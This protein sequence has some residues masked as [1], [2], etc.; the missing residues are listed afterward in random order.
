MATLYEL[1]TQLRQYY[2]LRYELNN[3]VHYL[4][5]SI[6]YLQPAAKNFLSAYSVDD[7]SKGSNSITK[8]VNELSNERNTINNT[9]IPSIDYE[10]SEL[11][12]KIEEEQ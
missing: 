2:N 9:I 12:R 5:N 1:E 3:I 4:N 8:Y 7:A 6:N 11:R 10:I